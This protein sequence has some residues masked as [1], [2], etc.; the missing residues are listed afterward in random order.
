MTENLPTPAWFN[1]KAVI[2]QVLEGRETKDI[3][4]DLGVTRDKLTYYLLHRTPEDWK[5]AQ[6][7]RAI[8]RK[9][10]AEQAIDDAGDIMALNKANS[11]LKSA[12]W[13]LERTCRRIYGDVKPVEAPAA[14]LVN[15]NL[16]RDPV[17]PSV[18][19]NDA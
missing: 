18:I 1:A 19:E 7:I 15:I 3:A 13:D 9:E 4:A 10:E 11:K 17:V 2:A 5:E 14:V 12:Q 8:K 6:V 16:R